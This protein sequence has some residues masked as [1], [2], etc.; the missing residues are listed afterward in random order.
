MFLY[1]SCLLLYIFYWTIYTL[2]RFCLL[3]LNIGCLFFY[4]EYVLTAIDMIVFELIKVP[5]IKLP[6]F[7][8]GSFISYSIYF[9]YMVYCLLLCFYINRTQ[10]F[11]KPG[12]FFYPKVN[13]TV[14][15]WSIRSMMLHHILN[16]TSQKFLQ[17]VLKEQQCQWKRNDLLNYFFFFSIRSKLLFQTTLRCLSPEPYLVN[18]VQ[19]YDAPTERTKSYIKRCEP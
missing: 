13:P 16:S 2:F 10:Y 15:Q 1:F 3:L 17:R 6:L 7:Q 19:R 12:P 8:L 5:S 14:F 9:V 18:S 4:I 11:G